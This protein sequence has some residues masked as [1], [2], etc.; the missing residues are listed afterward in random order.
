MEVQ[1]ATLTAEAQAERERVEAALKAEHAAAVAEAE[2][3]RQAAEAERQAAEAALREHKRELERHAALL[4]KVE[5]D[6]AALALQ[7][8]ENHD[9]EITKVEDL[10]EKIGRDMSRTWTVA[11]R[12]L[13]GLTLVS[14][15]STIFGWSSKSMILQ[16]VGVLFTLAAGYQTFKGFTQEPAFGLRNLLDR[17]ARKRFRA[18]L[19]RLGID[20]VEY[21]RFVKVDCGQLAWVSI[22]PP[23]A[24]PAP[25]QIDVSEV[26]KAA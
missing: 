26:D 4:D 12:V 17:L 5:R 15:A 25:S 9:R 23:P 7:V 18:G 6:K 16:V 14:L 13:V 22:P 19:D 11:V 20:E 24:L 10:M 2:A 3:K 1:K 8:R 21:M